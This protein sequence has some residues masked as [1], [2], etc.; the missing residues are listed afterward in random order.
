VTATHPQFT[1]VLWSIAEVG[2]ASFVQYGQAY[3]GGPADYVYAVIPMRSSARG[4]VSNSAYDFVPAFSLIRGGRSDLSLQ[5]NW[6]FFCVTSSTPAWCS[7][8]SLARPIILRGAKKFVPRAGMSWNPGLGKFM[9][10]L[11]VDPVPENKDGSRFDGG[12]MLSTS[13]NPWGPWT[14]EFSSGGTWPGGQ[15]SAACRYEPWGA[16]ERADIPTKYMS[17]DGRTFYLFSSDGDCLSIARG[18]LR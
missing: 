13:R 3:A 8:V 9:L 4:D 5:N 12:L 7:S 16:G 10:A 1:W 6:E 11:V 14:T 2:Y 18:V 17:A 15:S